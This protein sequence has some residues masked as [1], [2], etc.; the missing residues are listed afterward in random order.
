MLRGV[1]RSRNLPM[2]GKSASGMD[3]L[4]G[5]PG[6]IP[7]GTVEPLDRQSTPYARHRNATGI[8]LASKCG[9]FKTVKARFWPW[10]SG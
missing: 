5:C 7:R 4:G 6:C 9:T 8:P 2:T 1:V 3:Y 10:L